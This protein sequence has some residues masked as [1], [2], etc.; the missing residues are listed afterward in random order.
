MMKIKNCA[1]LQ[2][3]RRKK[4]IV[5]ILVGLVP[6][7]PGIVIRRL[8]YRNVS[9]KFSEAL[10][11]TQN[12]K[13][14]KDGRQLPNLISAAL[15]E[16]EE[17]AELLYDEVEEAIAEQLD[18]YLGFTDSVPTNLF[19]QTLLHQLLSCTRQVMNV[20]TVAVLLKT[21][22]GQQLAVRATIGLE[23]E[24]AQEIRIPLGQGFAGRIAASRQVAIVDDLS[25]VEVVSPILR[26]KGLQS[27][28]G[29]PLLVK[30]RVI[31]VFHVGTIPPRQFTEEEAQLLKLVAD[32]V[33]LA[34]DRLV[35][36]KLL[37][38]KSSMLVQREKFALICSLQKISRTIG[39]L[40][41]H[42]LPKGFVELTPPK[43]FVSTFC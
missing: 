16:V 15:A 34:I 21:E 28:L 43:R 1:S 14:I 23:E 11:I 7:S 10:N 8:M 32:H 30:N 13:S 5:T 24:I 17:T 4:S 31:G 39:N 19:L 3:S 37:I 29:V 35:I 6:F 2:W 38:T 26:N 20:D 40:N 22:D 33:G 36:S 41:F 12:K 9:T 27:M 42:P 18:H 25:K